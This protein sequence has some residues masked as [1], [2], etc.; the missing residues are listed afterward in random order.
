MNKKIIYS[1][2]IILLLLVAV[3]TITS[4]SKESATNDEL[5]HIAA[6]YSYLA[7]GDFRAN[8]EHPPLIKELSAVPLLFLK[9]A[10]NASDYYWINMNDRNKW[11]WGHDFFF[12]YNS[13]ADQLLFW[14]RIPMVAIALLLG[15]Y[16]F[17]WARD[18]FG[19]K[20]GLFALFLYS[21]SPDILAHAR[22]VHTDLGVA[23]FLF[24]SSYYLWRFFNKANKINLVLTGIFFGLALAAKF[25]ALYF[26]PV[27]GLLFAVFIFNKQLTKKESL[28]RLLNYAILLAVI[29]FISV[30]I[31]VL[32]YFF[33]LAAYPRGLAHVALHST[34]GHES[35]LF[36]M[37]S[38][39]GFWYYFFVAFFLKTPIPT[40]IFILLALFYVRRKDYYNE[41]FIIIPV[42]VFFFI[43]LFNKINIGARHILVVY[44][45]LFVFA[46]R[47]I[48]IK[49]LLGVIAALSLWYLVSSLLIYPHYLAYFNEFAGGPDNGYKYLIDSNI[50]WGQDL[51]GLKEYLV[52]NNINEWI[53]LGYFGKDSPEYR[54]INYEQLPCY[55]VKGTVAISVNLLQ[56][57]DEEQELC[58]SWLR[59]Y[60][61]ID[62]IGYSIFIYNITSVADVEEKISEFCRINCKNKCKK[63]NL[64]YINSSFFNESCS[65]YC[66]PAV[67]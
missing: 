22:I 66:L 35:Y 14:A 19:E 17:L 40:M 51:K 32:A 31:L 64:I 42:L 26:I 62:K 11:Q 33:Q 25:T 36:G 53:Y 9:P 5:V 57:L 63:E 3:Q 28:N 27:Y 38:F 21:F 65:C 56:G 43:S 16:V 52:K 2:V 4:M 29:L 47:L 50:D 49:K 13:N 34:L 58:S 67:G 55:P 61:P 44:P 23:A 54:Q 12:K 6:G 60:E 8:P 39:T 20:A 41:S 30:L 46:S 59:D 7:T 10:F 24:I 48:S 15:I 1:A 45:F 37:R 18:L